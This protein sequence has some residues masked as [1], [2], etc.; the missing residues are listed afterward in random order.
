MREVATAKTDASGRFTLTP[1][2]GATGMFYLVQTVYQ[3]VNYRSR[4]EDR[5]ATTVTVYETT[6]T[7]P[8]LRI[9]SARIVVEAV[10]SSAR[11]IFPR[12][13]S[14]GPEP[15]TDREYSCGISVVSVCSSRIS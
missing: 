10:P 2:A 14:L 15:M 5:G 12:K 7:P 13:K 9:R 11:S 4:V 1:S 6:K 3:G 8:A